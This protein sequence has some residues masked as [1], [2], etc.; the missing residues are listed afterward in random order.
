[1]RTTTDQSLKVTRF[2]ELKI[3]QSAGRRSP[4]TRNR[5]LVRVE[6]ASV[7]V[8][9]VMAARGDYHLQPVPGFVTGYDF[10]GIVESLPPGSLSGLRVGQRVAGVL[11]AMG[12]HATRL[13]VRPDIL[14]PV[15]SALH[16]ASAAT[17]LLDAVTAMHALR[18]AN[19]ERGDS[20][21][22]QGAGGAFGSW[23]V[24]FGLLA[25]LCVYG[26]ASNRS[27]SHATS[28]GADCYD[29]THGDWKEQLLSAASGGVDAVIDHT[30]DRE[31]PAVVRE[32]GSIVRIAFGGQSGRQ[33]RATV[34]GSVSTLL[35]S[36]GNPREV[37]CSLPLALRTKPRFLR[38]LLQE[39]MTQAA[40]GS[41]RPPEPE[42]ISF[43]DSL[44]CFAQL[45]QLP[46]GRKAVLAMP[47]HP[48]P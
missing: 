32:G 3:R 27:A 35:R 8:T 40:E 26:T 16:A 33:R 44:Q 38:S 5:A 41:V 21:L 1:M 48:R 36:R 11:P 10:V 46:A 4:A 28:L 31:L 45:A 29:Y 23:A 2:G 37:L 19:L 9:D 47:D 7:G 20:V 34:H 12:A 43:E 24:Q 13:A 17:I 6:Y 22:I 25:G 15:P 42:R 14:V 30:G 18:L 39:A